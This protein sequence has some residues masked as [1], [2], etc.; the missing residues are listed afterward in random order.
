MGEWSRYC[1]S[2]PVEAAVTYSGHAALRNAHMEII[3]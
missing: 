1:L 3:P 2:T